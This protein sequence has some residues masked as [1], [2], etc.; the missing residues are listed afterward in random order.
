MSESLPIV[1]LAPRMTDDSKAI[2]KT[3]IDLGWSPER[4]QGWRVPDHITH[5]DRKV[6]IYG[7]PLF[8]E[9]VCDQIGHVLLEPPIDWLTTLP[10]KYLSRDISIMT[11]AEAREMK[12][13]AF[14]KPADG[15]I[16]DPKVYQTGSD[17]PADDQVDLD[18][19]VL[20][21]EVVDFRL[22]V[23]CFIRGRAVVTQ[24]PYWR[25]DELAIDTHSNWPFLESEESAALTFV[26]QILDDERIAIPPA[27]TIDV[28][29][30]PDDSWA[31]I[32]SNPAWGAGLYGCDPKEVLLSIGDAIIPSNQVDESNKKW[33]SLRRHSIH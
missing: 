28:G 1:I 18:I 23:R 26:Q 10:H 16:F 20:R 30:L 3:C 24:S 12:Q 21:S 33:I 19:G 31:I 32:E 5:T 27:C 17:L 8:A 4:M 11:L 6:I 22:E 9:A 14:V 25:N 2:W 7:E 13:R 15:K 29:K